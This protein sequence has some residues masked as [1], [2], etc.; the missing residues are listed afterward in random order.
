[1]NKTTPTGRSDRH[2]IFQSAVQAFLNRA[3]DEEPTIEFDG[4][5]FTVSRACE[6]V[7]NMPDILPSSGMGGLCDVLD[8]KSWTYAAVARAIHARIANA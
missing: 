7:W 8:F 3:G 2:E 5:E 6:M 4:V 1:M